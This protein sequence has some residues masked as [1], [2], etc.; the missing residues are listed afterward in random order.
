MVMQYSKGRRMAS[1][2]YDTLGDRQVSCL[3]KVK[4]QDN[5]KQKEGNKKQHTERERNGEINGGY[6]I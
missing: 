6:K 5:L 4:T 3:K 2:E 1:E